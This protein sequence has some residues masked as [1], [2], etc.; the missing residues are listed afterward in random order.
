MRL[1]VIVPSNYNVRLFSGKCV[2]LYRHLY[3]STYRS[4]GPMSIHLF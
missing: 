1:F 2:S 4:R 3:I